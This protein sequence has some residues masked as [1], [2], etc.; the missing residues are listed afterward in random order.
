MHF[1]S[2]AAQVAE[3]HGLAGNQ[4]FPSS[5]DRGFW[6]PVQ[7]PHHGKLFLCSLG[8]ICCE[9]LLPQ[10]PGAISHDNGSSQP[11]RLSEWLIVP[12]AGAYGLLP[13]CRPTHGLLH[14]EQLWKGFS[15]APEGQP[16]VISIRKSTRLCVAGGGSGSAGPALWCIAQEQRCRNAPGV[17]GSSRT[18]GQGSG[19]AQGGLSCVFVRNGSAVIFS[20]RAELCSCIHLS[21]PLVQDLRLGSQGTS[22]SGRSLGAVAL[23]TE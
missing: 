21:D 12:R 5:Q 9:N 20:S 6:N 19:R 2:C 1:L 23:T 3:L 18:A 13:C 16:S 22:Q 15:G 8:L 7:L 14:E 10:S 17:D 4:V 11:R